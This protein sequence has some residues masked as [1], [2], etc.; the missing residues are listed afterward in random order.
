MFAALLLPPLP[1]LFGM[2][3]VG[4]FLW[5]GFGILTGAFIALLVTRWGQYRPMRKCIALSV[6]THFL[7]ALYALTIDIMPK[8][9]HP[10]GNDV[11]VAIVDPAQ[12]DDLRD[13]EASSEQPDRP[14]EKFSEPT[15][16][17]M[18][19]PDLARPAESIEPESPLAAKPELPLPQLIPVA[20]RIAAEIKLPNPATETMPQ[21]RVP[22]P[23][24]E[25][26]AAPI[27]PIAELPGASVPAP[28]TPPR[29]TPEPTTTAATQELLN[30]T[31]VDP[32]RQMPAMYQL[33]QSPDRSRVAQMRG[34]SAETEA[35]VASALK[36]LA[37]NQSRD[38]RWDASQFGSGREARIFGQDRNSTGTEADTGIT[39]L[40][41]LAFLG[42]GHTHQSGDYPQQVRSAIDFLLREQ[43]VDGNLGGAADAYAFMYCHGMASLA[44]SEALGMTGDERLKPAVTRAVN[45]TLSCQNRTTGGW[46]YRPT[47]TGDTSQLGW[48]LMVLKSAELAGVR[49][50]AEPKN[51]AKQFLESVASGK[52][53]GLASYRPNEPVTRTMTAEA[54]WCR[55]FLGLPRTD[56]ACDE[57][58]DF[59]LEEL[60]GSNQTNLYYWYYATLSM[61]QLQGRHWTRWNDALTKT[62]TASQAQVGTQAGSWEPDPIW[63]NY[64]GRVYSTALGALCLE[65]YYR[66]LPLYV[67]E[68]EGNLLR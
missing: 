30:L 67:A 55:Q 40:A 10:R 47:E 68:E 2:Q 63:G 13:D 66:F 23:N 22:A 33:R 34:G 61:Y 19:L 29:M 12:L 58:G 4:M 8:P 56:P 24:I 46:R 57:A 38:G 35:A 37:R 31:K 28:S 7:L 16:D 21:V 17:A 51:R 14:W 11:R 15:P 48:Q 18:P 1:I 36:W 5:V 45:Y 53:N 27:A 9:G 59:V 20:P 26:T 65:V 60:P 52:S 54:L 25:P 6:W 3:W 32:Q 64:G 49:V 62:L 43:G 50:P 39:G 41:L 42:A 44:L